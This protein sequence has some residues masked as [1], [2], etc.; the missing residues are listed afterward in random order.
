[1]KKNLGG[2]QMEVN[3]FYKKIVDDLR[4]NK[5]NNKERLIISL[6]GEFIGSYNNNG[7]HNIYRGIGKIL[8]DYGVRDKSVRIRLLKSYLK[9][10]V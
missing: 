5:T 10:I 8:R 1:M 4:G 9:F 7:V 3:I 6:L 2:Q